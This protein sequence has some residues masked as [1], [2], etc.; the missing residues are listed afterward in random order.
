MSSDGGNTR[1]QVTSGSEWAFRIDFR[2]ADKW[3]VASS[4]SA[5]ELYRSD[6]ASVTLRTLAAGDSLNEAEMLT[7]EGVG[8]LSKDAAKTAAKRWRDILALLSVSYGATVDFGTTGQRSAGDRADD[9]Y[10][11][12]EGRIAF[13]SPGM[14]IYRPNVTLSFTSVSGS[15]SA[16]LSEDEI[17]GMF[18]FCDLADAVFD[19][20]VFAACTLYNSSML[21]DNQSVRLVLL[22]TAVESLTHQELFSQRV[23]DLVSLLE[24]QVREAELSDSERNVLI[25]RLKEARKQ[26]VAAACRDLISRYLDCNYQE[27]KRGQVPS[28][29][30]R[31]TEQVRARR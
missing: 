23:Q 7:L 24:T 9:L 11:Y 6:N 5:I 2:P 26:S 15:L 30:V 25:G 16:A 17:V 13:V 12:P 28:G 20:D 27:P 22:I 4:A 1:T 8:Y 14:T 29:S 19:K 10:N 18:E 21:E 3:T 31:C